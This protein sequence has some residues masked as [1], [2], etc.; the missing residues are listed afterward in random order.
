[1]PQEAFLKILVT[2][3][4]GYIGSVVVSELIRAGHDVIVYDNLSRGHRQ[5]VHSDADLIVADLSDTAVLGRV[6]AEE[7][8]E[9]VMHFAASIEAGESMKVPEQFFRNNTANTLGILETMLQAGVRNIVFSSTAALYGEPKSTPIRE[10]DE[11]CPTNAYGESKLLVERML[12]WLNRIH[13]LRYASLRYFNAAGA[14]PELGE[15]HDPETHLI[16][17]VLQVAAGKRPSISIFGT[18]YPTIDGSCVRDY[19]HVLDLAQAHVLALEGLQT[20]DKLIYNIGNGSGFSV[21]QIVEAARRITGHAIPVVESPRRP[22][23]PAVLVA[24]SEK[25]RNELRWVPKYPDPETII[26]SAWDWHRRNP[27]GYSD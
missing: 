10:T 3:G 5:A 11:L 19:I 7:K 22:G 23:D 20:R 1:M 2:G 26:E 4:A 15:G 13:G 27:N 14:T 24:S 8:I 9:A 16:P 25:I 12:D 17:L 21:R 18:D 6:L